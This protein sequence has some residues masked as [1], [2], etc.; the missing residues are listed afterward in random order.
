VTTVGGLDL[1]LELSPTRPARSLAA[2]LRAA[3]LDGRL[4][5]ETRLPA[6]RSLAA[7]LGVS[8]NTVADVYAQLAAE[9]WLESRIGAGTWVSGQVPAATPEPARPDRAPRRWIDLRGGIP[10][11]T[12]FARREWV[13]AVRAAMTRATAADLGYPDP[14]GTARLRSALAGYLARTRGVVAHPDAVLVGSAFGELLVL[15]GRA[16]RERGA[17]RVAVEAYGHGY[18]RD[19]ITST[20]LELV[21][22]PVDDDGADVAAVDAAGVDAVLLTPAHQ[23]PVGVPL[24]AHRRRFLLAWASRRGAVVIEDDYDGEF[25]YDRRAIGALQ[26]LAPDRVVYLGT[27]SKAVAPSVGLAWAV[28]PEWLRPPVLEQR[29][30]SGGQPAALQQLAAAEFIDA[31]EYDRSVRRYRGAFR[32]RRVRLEEVVDEHLPGCTV[33]GLAAGLQCLLRLP[34]GTDE[35]RVE[36]AAQRRGLRLAGLDSQRAAGADTVPFPAIVIGYGGPTPGQYETALTLLVE[37]V[38]ESLD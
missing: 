27:A 25:R 13:A 33:T 36:R 15:V 4:G 19:L 17:R 8:R 26:A 31:H 9:G 30:L 37:S 2:T 29:R 12:G 23:Y 32:A 34:P 6:A 28:L 35:R 10:D 24:A 5:P 7:D 20:S 16:L 1:H 14:A 22:I 11:A 3:I 38:R 21:P 18:H